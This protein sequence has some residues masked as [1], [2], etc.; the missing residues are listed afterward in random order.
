MF[1]QNG[2]KLYELT[3]YFGG[4]KPP[5]VE[6]IAARSPAGAQASARGYLRRW[7]AS[8]C[9]VKGETRNAEVFAKIPRGCFGYVLRV[10]GWEQP[11]WDVVIAPT[12]EQ[13]RVDALNALAKHPDHAKITNATVEGPRSMTDPTHGLGVVIQ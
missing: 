10:A 3:V 2:Q 9:T 11:Y 6:Q 13:A 12:L 5:K 7:N 4:S 8:R 1:L